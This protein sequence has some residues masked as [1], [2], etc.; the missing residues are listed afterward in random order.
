MVAVGDQ[1]PGFELDGVD[2]RSG[3]PCRFS[4][5]GLRGRP[6]V[7]VFYPND[8]SPLCRRQLAEYTA[9]IGSFDQLDAQVLGLSPWSVASHAKFASR[10][11]GFGFPLL[12]DPA[13][14]VARAYGVLGLLDL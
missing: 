7:L 2:G 6:V 13:K 9:G 11:G 3:A 1:A 8:N 4:L 14:D 10:S 5:E 12:S